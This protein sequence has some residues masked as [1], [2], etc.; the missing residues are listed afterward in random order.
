LLVD[1]PKLIVSG[2]QRKENLSPD[3][4]IS[5]Y[6]ATGIGGKGGGSP[7]GTVPVGPVAGD[8]SGVAVTT[9]TCGVME[10]AKVGGGTLLG[11]SVGITVTRTVCTMT[12]GVGA[13]P[14]ELG[15]APHAERARLSS[16]IRHFFKTTS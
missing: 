2:W 4:V 15:S 14:E 11:S 16:T 9:R 6:V 12:A 13:T 7:A 10:G 5:E 1:T 8:A 3:R